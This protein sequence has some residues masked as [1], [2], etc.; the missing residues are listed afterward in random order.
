MLPAFLLP[1]SLVRSSGQGP[2]LD[3]GTSPPAQLLV[4]LGITRVIEQESL[5]LALLASL[6][7]E[8]WA[9]SP[10]L[11]FPQKFYAGVSS[12]L[13]DAAHTPGL[14]FL[15]ARWTLNRWGRGDQSPLFSFYVFVEPAP[16]PLDS[17]PRSSSVKVR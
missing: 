17:A 2:R 1:E 6:D 10:I 8:T 7:G 11:A 12:L 13:L 4:T 5:D 14:R 3:L 15:R 16:L 9:P